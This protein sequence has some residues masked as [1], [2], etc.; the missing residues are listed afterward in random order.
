MMKILYVATKFDYGEPTQGPSYEHENFYDCLSHLG[1]DVLYFDSLASQRQL[2]RRRSSRRLCQI[3]AAER[4]QLMFSVLVNDELEW[5]AVR[6]IS[7]MDDVT[8]CNWF[9]D[10][11]WRFETF[12]R[13][14]APAFNWVVTTDVT[15][16]A[17]YHR[18]GYT[19]VLKSQWGVNPFRYQRV[20]VPLEFDVTFV[21]K[22]HG[23]RRQIIR[24][25][26][27]AKGAASVYVDVCIRCV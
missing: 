3:A 20:Q 18:M 27:D 14:W 13:H 26:A 17:K 8:T 1:H 15:A 21:G 23:V 16:P 5:D 22:P 4:P 9:C 10:D 19:R 2:G 6:R 11:H 7:D 12:S 24:A 25:L